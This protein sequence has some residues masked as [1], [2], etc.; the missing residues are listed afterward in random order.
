[1]EPL[2]EALGRIRGRVEKATKGPW[3]RDPCSLS[4][5]QVI[6]HGNEVIAYHRRH[7]RQ[8]DAQVIPNFEFM[9]E[10]RELVPALIEA[11]EGLA[12]ALEK[13]GEEDEASCGCEDH[14]G[15]DCCNQVGFVCL[16]CYSA[17]ALSAA[18]QRLGGTK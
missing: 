4:S 6:A 9:A 12:K 1:M 7:E 10:S 15:E 5:L 17:A 13:L 14:G 8:I 2:A 18:A 3:L 11:C 16:R